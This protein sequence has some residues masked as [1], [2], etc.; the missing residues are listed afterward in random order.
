MG[1]HRQLLEEKLQLQRAKNRLR[2]LRGVTVEALLAKDSA[3]QL[4]KLLAEY[5]HTSYEQNTPPHSRLPLTAEENV[6]WAWL[7]TELSLE[8]GAM[9]Y[10]CCEGLWAKLRLLELVPAVSS[11][12]RQ[13]TGHGY[14]T[15]FL[16]ISGDL[17]WLLEAGSDSRD[18]AHYLV[19]IWPC[20]RERDS[21]KNAFRRE[22]QKG[23][24]RAG[25]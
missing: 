1:E 23:L 4:D 13:E 24:R 10:Y 9:Y 21:I 11:L 7:E 25:E 12:W 22:L 2:E 18:E 8:T 6:I 17:C 3:P 15:G 16:L 14:T 5:A 19:D 20:P